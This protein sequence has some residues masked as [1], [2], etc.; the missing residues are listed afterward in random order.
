MA[1]ARQR[2]RARQPADAAAGDRMWAG[3]RRLSASA[4]R[5][6][7][8]SASALRPALPQLPQL[9]QEPQPE[10]L[11][12]RGRQLLRAFRIDQAGAL[13]A[14]RELL[15]GRR[16]RQPAGIQRHTA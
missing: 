16:A 6:V 15:R 11:A 12:E 9:S 3:M 4:W 10:V 8:P 1:P 5:A 2:Q 14:R 7:W 13:R